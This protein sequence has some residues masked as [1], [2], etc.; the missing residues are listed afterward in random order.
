M[1]WRA[2]AVD[3]VVDLA[4]FER[5]AEGRRDGARYPEAF[6]AVVED[7]EESEGGVFSDAFAGVGVDEVPGAA[8][9]GVG[10]VEAGVEGFERVE[11]E[12]ARTGFVGGVD[13]VVF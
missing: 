13:G 5:G 1:S 2:D 12:V 8:N 6:V 4:L 10:D 9:V 7:V 3:L 11:G